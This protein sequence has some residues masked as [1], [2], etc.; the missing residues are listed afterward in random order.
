MRFGIFGVCLFAIAPSAYA[1]CD[2]ILHGVDSFNTAPPGFARLLS[3]IPSREQVVLIRE[4]H[5]AR[6][7]RDY[8][9][10]EAPLA[11]AVDK[12]LNNTLGRV[13]EGIVQMSEEDRFERG[14]PNYAALKTFALD[15]KKIA[16]Q[17]QFNPTGPRE[18]TFLYSYSFASQDSAVS[19][20]ARSEGG[21]IAFNTSDKQTE[22]LLDA[23]GTNKVFTEVNGLTV[24][25]LKQLDRIYGLDDVLISLKDILGVPLEKEPSHF[26]REL[27]PFRKSR[28]TGT[29]ATFN[30]NQN[31]KFFQIRAL[32]DNSRDKIDDPDVPSR[33]YLLATDITGVVVTQRGRFDVCRRNNSPQTPPRIFQ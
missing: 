32:I 20:F 29:T 13:L 25:Y 22:Y 1:K 15:W 33:L 11:P 26:G 3:E 7:R 27:G 17:L 5:V 4:Q 6:V 9:T 14:N 30:V 19:A 8:R 31:G 21:A 23:T 28:P 24:L 10:A 18:S 16:G 2:A 12:F